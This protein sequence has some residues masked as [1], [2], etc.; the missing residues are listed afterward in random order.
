MPLQTKTRILALDYGKSRIGVAI[1][2]E[3]A[4]IALPL[5]VLPQINRD[6]DLKAIRGLILEHEVALIVMGLPRRSES[7][8]GP[9]AEH[10]MRF[11]KRLERFCGLPLEFI[12]EFET[13]VEAEQVLLE[14]DVS[15]QKR[16]QAVDKLAAQVILKRY[17]D[18]HKE[19][20]A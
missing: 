20:E 19:P 5:C 13:T 10:I 1:S 6:K 7:E 17:L 8:L 18:A 9:A 11:G 2:D 3:T 4:S 15:R 16:R 14:A 12:D